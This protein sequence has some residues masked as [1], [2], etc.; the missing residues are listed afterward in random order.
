LRRRAFE[1]IFLPPDSNL[2]LRAKNLFRKALR[3]ANCG[4]ISMPGGMVNLPQEIQKFIDYID[5][6]GRGNIEMAD[7]D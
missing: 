6:K 2:A 5:N 4:E 3:M 1:P 7:M